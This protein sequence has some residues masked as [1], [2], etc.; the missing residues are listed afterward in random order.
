MD[1]FEKP[2]PIDCGTDVLCCFDDDAPAPDVW[3]AVGGIC[4]AA[5][6]A[7]LVAVVVW[8]LRCSWSWL[9]AEVMMD[10]R[11]SSKLTTFGDS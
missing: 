10:F 9:R 11:R 2:A 3:A 7:V 1:G 4:D 5:T 6:V 8:A